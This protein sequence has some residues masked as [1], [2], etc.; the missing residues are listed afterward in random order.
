MKKQQRFTRSA[1]ALACALCIGFHAN[2]ALTDGLVAHYCFDDASNLGK[3]CSTNGNNGT[4]SGSVVAVSGVV[5]GGAK[6]G[7]YSNPGVIRV[8]NSSSLKFGT[9]MSLS[10]FLKVDDRSGINGNGFVA[11]SGNFAIIAKSH[12]RSGMVWMTNTSETNK[13]VSWSQGNG[14]SVTA[15]TE[16]VSG[17]A[18]NTLGRWVHV[19]E[20]VSSNGF[21]TYMDGNLARSLGGY[22]DFTV[23]NTQDLYIGK[24]SDSWY[25]LNGTLDDLRIYNR[26]L[27]T[28]EISELTNSKNTTASPTQSTNL[29][30][31]IL[32]NNRAAL[33]Y[34]TNTLTVPTLDIP[35][36]GSS[37]LTF[38]STWKATNATAPNA[39][40][41]LADAQQISNVSSPTATFDPVTF[42]VSM[43]NVITS[44]SNN[45]TDG[46]AAQKYQVIVEGSILGLVRMGATLNCTPPQVAQNGQCVTPALN[47]KS[48]GTWQTLSDRPVFVSLYGAD[49]GKVA[50]ATLEGND[51]S[52]SSARSVGTLKTFQCRS[53]SVGSETVVYATLNYTDGRASTKVGPMYINSYNYWTSYNG[54]FYVDGSKSAVLVQKT[55]GSVDIDYVVGSFTGNNGDIPAW[56]YFNAIKMTTSSGTVSCPVS[57]TVPWRY[58]CPSVPTGSATLNLLREQ[59][60]MQ[61]VGSSDSVQIISQ[62]EA[63]TN[64]IPTT[65]TPVTPTCVAP[66][67]LQ[68]NVCVTPNPTVVTTTQTQNQACPAGQTGTIQQERTVTITNGVSSYGAW[69]TVSN[70]CSTPITNPPASTCVNGT[71]ASGNKC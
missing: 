13:L 7:G 61:V 60:A 45:G 54:Q 64:G 63:T 34:S 43:P 47:F 28:S 15:G 31:L 30:D 19:V 65:S 26:V 57:S 21:K 67:V 53:P 49:V 69:S 20:V 32:S 4:P 68:G 50:S 8:P 11:N 6:F 41:Y 35:Q 33:N 1:I 29:V 40:F 24:F 22:I 9:M 66:Q 3:D 52:V 56:T 25:P 58:S 37:P 42:T 55:D 16:V 70:S 71:D 38:S 48:L 12:D 17:W 59:G 46:L 36:A 10:Y 2:A 39:V 44:G 23:S 27:S 5:G 18:N 62:A 14:V 51:C